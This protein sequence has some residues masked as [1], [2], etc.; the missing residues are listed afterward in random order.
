MTTRDATGGR[1]LSRP[2]Q[3]RWQAATLQESQTHAEGHLDEG[4][5]LRCRHD[6]GASAQTDMMIFAR[7]HLWRYSRRTTK[8]YH[9]SFIFPL[10]SFYAGQALLPRRPQIH[11][12]Q[13]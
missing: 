6:Y 13:D 11:I 3:L 9:F 8:Y 12:C 5:R 1:L 7:R 2:G 4:R 10:I